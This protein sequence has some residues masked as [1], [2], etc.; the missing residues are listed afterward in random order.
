MSTINIILRKDKIKKTTG[1][2]PLYMRVIEGEKI[3]VISLGQDILEEEWDDKKQKAKSKH[4]NSSRINNLISQKLSEAES[5]KIEL[6][7][8]PG[9]GELLKK[10]KVKLVERSFTG[11]FNEYLGELKRAQIAGTF[12]KSESILKKL[13]DYNKQRDIS[14]KELD[15]EF[16]KNYEKHLRKLGN[17]TNTIHANFRVIRMLLNRAVKEDV[18]LIQDNPF[19]KFKSKKES[20]EKIFLTENE[21][22]AF[23][24]ISISG[25]TQKIHQDMFVFASYTGGIRISDLLKLKWENFDGKHIN[26][27]IQKTKNHLSI[28]VPTK[29]LAIMNK[30]KPKEL[31]KPVGYI[32]PILKNEDDLSNPHDL[33]T[34]ISSATAHANKNL[35][36]IAK[37]AKIEK[38]ITFHSSRHTWATRALAKGMPVTHVSKLMGHSNLQVT[39]GYA[40]IVNKDLDDAMEV[41]N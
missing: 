39:M 2:C 33:L 8:K 25:S 21:L 20:V 26:I 35:K 34:K 37:S 30:Y 15:L 22:N 13:T 14:F 36:F 24:S 4:S 9:L 19:Q 29:G 1:K 11:Y 3:T 32:F 5:F 18:I 27:F 16:L 41:F 31:D 6:N 10:G 28:N 23:E 17:S 40:K 7:G 38:I 12:R